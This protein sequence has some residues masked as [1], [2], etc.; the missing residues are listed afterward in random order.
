[1]SDSLFDDESISFLI[2]INDE[3]Q[4]SI[5]PE[6]LPI[7]DGWNRTQGPMPRQ[8]CMDWLTDHWTDL[9]PSSLRHALRTASPQ[10]MKEAPAS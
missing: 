4:Y 8:L 10:Q 9:R 7:P 6:T 5:W 2:L 1:M 3:H